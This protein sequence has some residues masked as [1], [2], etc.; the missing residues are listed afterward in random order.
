MPEIYCPTVRFVGGPDAGKRD[1]FFMGIGLEGEGDTRVVYYFNNE[2]RKERV[3]MNLIISRS[4]DPEATAFAFAREY[5]AQVY[6][7]AGKKPWFRAWPFA[8]QGTYSLIAVEGDEGWELGLG[9]RLCEVDALD[10]AGRVSGAWDAKLEKIETLACSYHS[11]LALLEDCQSAPYALATAQA[12]AN[13]VTDARRLARVATVALA[14]YDPDSGDE[15]SNGAKLMTALD[16]YVVLLET[17][18]VEVVELHLAIEESKPACSA[19]TEL[20]LLSDV[21]REHT[22]ILGPMPC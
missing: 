17:A 14:E 9:E 13:A 11:A 12:V 2:D 4:D 5:R 10:S 6:E 16:S 3:W 8:Y 15:T 18:V 22:E 21:T 19:A 1:S 20:A 7:L